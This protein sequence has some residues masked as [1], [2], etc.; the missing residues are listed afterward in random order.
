MN[1]A[2]NEAIRLIIGTEAVCSDGPV[3]DLFRVVIDPSART[4]T[5][6]VVEPRHRRGT[7]HLVPVG[8][9]ASVSADRISLNCTASE[10]G[11]LDQAEEIHFQ[12]GED[13]VIDFERSQVLTGPYY[14]LGSMGMGTGP[15][16]TTSDVVPEGEVEV[17]RGEPVLATDG[18]IGHVQGFVVD[19]GDHSVTYVLLA[20][21]H[22]WAKKRVAIP[23]TAVTR[24]DDGFRLS[25]SKQ[26]IEDLPAAGVDE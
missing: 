21:G 10:F 1:Q 8:L 12:L 3:G 5:H 6:L 7:G 26:E 9:V 14:P 4:V 13:S 24:L 18:A 15:Q 17:R 11:A 19:P 23:M 20:E 25:L 2:T 16:P 22:L